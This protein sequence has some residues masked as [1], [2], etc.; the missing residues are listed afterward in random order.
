M[1]VAR[2]RNLD[3]VNPVVFEKYSPQQESFIIVS[4]ILEPSFSQLP[5]NVL[6]IVHNKDDANYGKMLRRTSNNPDS[7]Y[8]GTW[9][10][11]QDYADIWAVKQFY[12][13]VS[14]VSPHIAGTDWSS[15]KEA[16]DIRQGLVLLQDPHPQQ[17][18]V[19][20][21][22]ERLSDKRTPTE[23][24]SMHPDY[25]RTMVHISGT[26]SED[27]TYQDFVGDDENFVK[28][29]SA[30]PP[31]VGEIFFLIGY[32]V[33][34][35]N[36]WY[37][38]WRKPTQ[39]DIEWLVP[40]VT[41][42][43]IT[44]PNN[45][46]TVL[47]NASTD[48]GAIVHYNNGDTVIEPTN[49]NWSIEEPNDLGITINASTGLIFV[50]DIDGDQT[51]TVNASYTD[52]ND[53]ENT[54]TAQLEVSISDDYQA[55]APVSFEIVGASTAESG[56]TEIYVF[57]LTY[58]D[59]STSPVR[60]DTVSID[61][62][63]SINVDGDA[64]FPV[65]AEDTT[66]TINA[67]YTVDGQTFTDTHEV[68]VEYIPV[69]SNM[70]LTGPQSVM[71]G[72]TDHEYVLTL[73][74]EDGES[75]EVV[76]DSITAS[77]PSVSFD[78]LTG[79]YGNIEQDTVVT[80]TATYTY[81]GQELTATL[82]VTV[83]A[84]VLVL[85][86]ADYMDVGATETYVVK[87]KKTDGSETVVTPI[88]FQSDLAGTTISGLDVTL[89]D[90]DGQTS[91]TLEAH[92]QDGEETLVATL[93]VAL[94]VSTLELTGP[95]SINEQGGQGTF[96][97]TYITGR[98][99]RSTVQPDSITSDVSALT[100]SGLTAT[101]GNILLDGTATVTATY[102]S[103][104]ETLSA[105]ATV[106]LKA[107]VLM[108]AGDQT[109]EGDQTHAYNIY[110]RGADGV[111]SSVQP[112]TFTSDNPDLTIVGKTVTVAQ[113]AEDGNA[114]LTATYDDGA[115]TMTA[116]LPVTITSLLRYESA[117]IEGPASFPMADSQNYRVRMHDNKGGSVVVDIENP[118]IVSAS[119]AA[120]WSGTSV[121]VDDTGLTDDY[122]F[123]IR[124]QG[125]VDG[126]TLTTAD[127]EVTA[128]YT[129]PVVT[130]LV[131]RGTLKLFTANAPTTGNY[132]VT[133]VYDNGDEVSVDPNNLTWSLP[134]LATVDVGNKS[135]TV[136]N[137]I[138]TSQ[139]GQLQAVGFGSNNAISSNV[140]NIELVS[141]PDAP[142]RIEITGNDTLNEGDS[143]TYTGNYTFESGNTRAAQSSEVNWSITS[144]A[145]Y[146]NGSKLSN[147][148]Y[149][150]T[151]KDVTQ[152]QTATIRVVDINDSSILD[153]FTI[154][155]TA[156]A[157]LQYI[158]ISGAAQGNESTGPYQL[159]ATAT[160]SDVTQAS[161]TDECTW[162]I[163]GNAH[164]ASISASGLLTIPADVSDDTVITIRATYVEG[165]NTQ[166]DDHQFTIRDVPKTI[167][168]LEITGATTGSESTGPYQLA[169]TAR[170]SDNS[171]LSVTNTATWTIV[172]NA[173][174]ASISSTGLLTLPANVSSDVNITIQAQY[175]DGTT[176]SD[177][178]VFAITD[179]PDQ[180]GNEYT[181]RWGVGIP[182]VTSLAGFD[183]A[184]AESL[185]NELTGTDGE[186][187][188]LN[189]GES[190]SANDTFFYILYPKS[191]GYLYAHDQSSNAYGGLDGAPWYN[192]SEF[193]F[194]GTGVD[195]TIGGND[196]VVYRNEWPTDAASNTWTLNYGSTDPK[197]GI[198]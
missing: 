184:F 148:T 27:D 158:Q 127:F 116:T 186:T 77:D 7:G 174:G 138:Y 59:T 43:E 69:A 20:D 79:T 50:P 93:D 86:G 124:G 6:W 37:G 51:F 60:P 195:V 132:T 136:A 17:R 16:T 41:S 64:T 178:H 8:K 190:T 67:S 99:D 166:T 96:V 183:A 58:D 52:P 134:A 160:Y 119:P 109:L 65:V 90:A 131:L 36:M 54:V 85:E 123:T 141:K 23:H 194:D 18:I 1:Y 162:E 88:L 38:E 55:P 133:A 28:V 104:S 118:E 35:P 92:Y 33:N 12:A 171:I 40:R 32:D 110:L 140:L 81:Q 76:P 157:E 112:D 196:Y 154:T 42:I 172:G 187:V 98:G 66:F 100:F 198:N 181:P 82:P 106:Q 145:A 146:I 63:A 4:G 45:A 87:L 108:I 25:P 15:I 56:S 170:Y 175:T 89:D 62:G 57:N 24:E 31:A 167:S 30:Q 185:T 47:D 103:G 155:I 117:T 122:V 149:L 120:T 182:R 70:V 135:L 129:A 156:D 72:T 197:S 10:V 147:G 94:G 137:P 164:G 84:D 29:V 26:Y 151:T 111:D 19:H 150:V 78:G 169:A 180:G 107:D 13:K 5:Y 189:G 121:S 163:V 152:Q 179:V 165:S 153:T 173:Q 144:G 39:T 102:T 191:L 74:F 75:I 97:L 143:A 177:T 21:Q 3:E 73:S 101:L 139:V 105:T 176:V 11:I 53:S 68:L 22:D 83:G 113:D 71:E 9:E 95:V 125:T 46:T 159:S 115:G 34:R 2:L 61:N 49:V 142:E 91:M 161:V 192:P 188:R 128:L 44:L 168:S 114:T 193:Y 130:A 126:T 48:L 14:D 80:L